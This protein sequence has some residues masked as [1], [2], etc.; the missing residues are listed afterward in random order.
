MRLYILFATLT[1]P[2][3]A[4]GQVA[5]VSPNSA[6]YDPIY[7][8]YYVAEAGSPWGIRNIVGGNSTSWVGT[9]FL[10]RDLLVKGDSL[11]CVHASGGLI[12]WRFP[13]TAASINVNVG[14]GQDLWGLTTN[15]P[16]LYATDRND[17][18]IWKINAMN[19]SSTFLSLSLG[20]EPCGIVYDPV[21]DRLLVGAWGTN[22]GIHAIDLNTG[23]DTL[24]LQTTYT[25]IHGITID[26]L[27]RILISTWF[28][29]QVVAYPA[30]LTGPGTVL[31]S[32]LDNPGFIHFDNYHGELMIPNTQS[33]LLSF[34]PINCSTD[35]PSYTR[36]T[37][38]LEP[39]PASDHIRVHL[40]GKGTLCIMDASGRR[41]LETVVSDAGSVNVSTLPEGLY[42][43]R[44][45]SWSTPLLISRNP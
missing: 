8:R 44:I 12:A 9:A 40:P 41:I 38:G 22:A 39:N 29:D 21:N 33:G 37:F 16:W 34:E 28:P 43:V 11:F 17:Q 20:W 30:D 6:A 25:N 35:I 15:G 10:P 42:F 31:F 36:P 13:S 26:C 5:F 45:G 24:L 3:V 2:V 32:G 19:G 7:D 27:G 4:F 1:I 18:S 23:E 14:F